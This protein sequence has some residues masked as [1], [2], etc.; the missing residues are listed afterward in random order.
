MLRQWMHQNGSSSPHHRDSPIILYDAGVRSATV[1]LVVQA[2]IACAYGEGW[3]SLVPCTRGLP[4][5]FSAPKCEPEALRRGDKTAE[6]QERLQERVETWQGD[7]D[8]ADV[9]EGQA[10]PPVLQLP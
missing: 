8:R 9:H 5:C 4:L 3:Q 10:A 7:G 2:I 6:G 1:A